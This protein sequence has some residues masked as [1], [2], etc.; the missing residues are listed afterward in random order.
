M[1][2]V[3]ISEFFYPY[4][5]STQKILTEL[6]EDLVESGLEVDVITTKNA[7]REEKIKLE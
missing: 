4:K 5:T 6:S 7:Y 2:I 1:K 3:L